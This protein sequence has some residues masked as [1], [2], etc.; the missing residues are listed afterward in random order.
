MRK[1]GTGTNQK[2]AG[3]GEAVLRGGGEPNWGK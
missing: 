3:D 1:Q 2:R